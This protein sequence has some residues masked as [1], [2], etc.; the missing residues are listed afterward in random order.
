MTI[1]EKQLEL[2]RDLADYVHG[3]VTLNEYLL[4][5][6][7]LVSVAYAI[8]EADRFYSLGEISLPTLT[9]LREYLNSNL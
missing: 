1:E 3:Y 7:A 4:K 9:H 5:C 8:E 6:K 2:A